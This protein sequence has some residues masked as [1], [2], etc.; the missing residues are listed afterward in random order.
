MLH[1]HSRRHLWTCLAAFMGAG[2]HGGHYH[3]GRWRR[4]EGIVFAAGNRVARVRQNSLVE[5]P[6]RYVIVQSNNQSWWN[7][8][9]SPTRYKS[10]TVFNRWRQTLTVNFTTSG[11]VYNTETISLFSLINHWI[12]TKK[13][14]LNNWFINFGIYQ[15]RMPNSFSNETL[16]CFMNKCAF[17]HKLSLHCVNRLRIQNLHQVKWNGY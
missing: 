9:W 16:C 1:W 10:A 11:K 5:P 17:V 12:K 15:V 14:N 13:N 6:P 8:R 4:R 7:T 3:L 2:S